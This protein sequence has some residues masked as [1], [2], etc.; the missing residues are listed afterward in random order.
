MKRLRW[1]A[2]IWRRLVPGLLAALL[3]SAQAVQ[4]A[5]TLP[6]PVRAVMDAHEL[7]DEAVS[8]WVQG[9]NQ[10]APR[11]AFNT[12]LPQNPASVM[13]LYTTYAALEALGPAYTWTTEVHA[14]GP[15]HDGVLEGDLWI[16]GSGDPYLVA[17]DLWRLLGEVRGRGIQ[18]I[19]GDLVL[20]TSA[21][22]H[23]ETDPGA[24][25]ERPFRAY[26]QQPHP[27]LINFNV[28]DFEL[29][30][31][32]DGRDIHV[33]TYPP[34]ANLPVESRLSASAGPCFGGAHSRVAYDIAQEPN[35]QAVILEGSYP[36]SCGRQRLTRSAMTPEDYVYG[37]FRAL[38]KQ[39]DGTF[40]GGLRSG[41]WGR[42]DTTPVAVRES[43]PLVDVVR[44]VNKYSNN[45][46]ARH[47]AL[48]LAVEHEAFP[49]TDSGSHEAVSYALARAGVD[50]TRMIM[51]NAAGLS[52]NNRVTARQVAALLQQART[53]LVMP[54]FK[55]S[56]AVAGRDGTL[57]NRF[58]DSPLTG[59][60]R[61]KTGSI[62]HVSA[63]AG[64]M[65]S[66]RDEDLLVVVLVNAE[67]AHRG[68]GR[69]VQD[70]VLQWAF[71]SAAP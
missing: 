9:V 65:R 4:A 66:A 24:F 54:E 30:P 21:F 18:R 60:A 57:R 5:D 31:S 37:L 14:D 36:V 44:L 17:R 40:E 47:L 23:S 67:D 49:A 42:G 28:L 48:T 45:V 29:E 43:R 38:W 13:K 68:A 69:A 27:L 1:V 19:T 39:W 59:R 41:E 53:S 56:L 3:G 52:R 8:V 20:D 46:M 32:L 64:Y 12:D 50:T 35:G 71:H 55:S 62:D 16:R 22:A 61:M 2:A 11:L 63:I 6:G 70:A 58:N 25:D 34:M 15:V 10:D 51:D 26:N 33:S 7:P